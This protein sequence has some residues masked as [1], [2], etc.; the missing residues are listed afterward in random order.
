[1]ADEMAHAAGV[2]LK[3]IEAE[4]LRP[5]GKM[6]KVE[7]PDTLDLAELC[8]LSVNVLIGNTDPHWQAYDFGVDPPRGVDRGAVLPKHIRTLPLLRAASGSTHGLEVEATQMKNQLES[9][10][11]QARTPDSYFF[12]P[13][14]GPHVLA[15]ANW[16]ERAGEPKY[17][18]WIAYLARLMREN[19]VLVGDRAYYPPSSMRDR[20]ANGTTATPAARRRSRTRRRTSRPPTSRGSRGP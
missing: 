10:T 4:S 15:L 3:A 14:Y 8:G 9:L 18:E 16:D 6:R 5:R 19:A 12:G 1:V 13:G 20:P 7:L 11:R 2:P 17:R